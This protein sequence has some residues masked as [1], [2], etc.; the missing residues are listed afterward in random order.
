VEV[1]NDWRETDSLVTA[2]SNSPSVQ[3]P[4]VAVLVREQN[5]REMTDR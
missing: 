2:V 1:K 4:D 5:T 3:A